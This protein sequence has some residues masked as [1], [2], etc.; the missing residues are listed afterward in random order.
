ML[1]SLL[2]VFEGV[3]CCLVI[4]LV[5]GTMLLILVSFLC[6]YGV[7]CFLCCLWALFLVIYLGLSVGLLFALL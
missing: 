3:V 1:V 6:M 7:C 5:Y 4:W 2:V